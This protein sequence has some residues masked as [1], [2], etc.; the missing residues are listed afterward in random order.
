LV[1]ACAIGV[2]VL[3]LADDGSS[4]IDGRLDRNTDS[5]FHGTQCTE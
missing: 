5:C 2:F 4:L 3:S 1:P